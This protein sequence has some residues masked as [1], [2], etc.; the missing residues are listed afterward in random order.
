MANYFSNGG[1]TALGTSY[2][3]AL[4]IVG[5]TGVRPKV[6]H[7]IASCLT[8]ADK[9]FTFLMQRLTGDGTGTSVTPGKYDPADPS[10]E[11]TSK[12]DYSGEP[13]Y[14]SGDTPIEIGNHQRGKVEWAALDDD[15]R[16]VVPASANN[17][18]GIQ[19]KH[20]SE[21]PATTAHMSWTE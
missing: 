6:Y 8:P 21:T 5:G 18:F 9:M 12:K 15:A 13:T 4:A 10:A 16:I 1:N 17:G 11:C 20:A 7:V 2:K 14:T 19:L 3:T